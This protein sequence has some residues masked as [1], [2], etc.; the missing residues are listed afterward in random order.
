MQ[1][2]GLEVSVAKFTEDGLTSIISACEDLTKIGSSMKIKIDQTHVMI[3]A[4]NQVKN[5]V[6]AMKTVEWPITYM[7]ES[8]DLPVA[9]MDFVVSVPKSFAKAIKQM[10]GNPEVAFK[11]RTGDKNAREMVASDGILRVRFIGGM[12]SDITDVSRADVHKKLDA[13]NSLFTFD[14]SEEDFGKAKSLAATSTAESVTIKIKAGK[15]EISAEDRYYLTVGH[16]SWQ[17]TK[18]MCFD[19]KYLRSIASKGGI[20]IHVFEHFMLIVEG[21]TH[22]MIG[23]EI[24]EL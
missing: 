22:F 21:N 19:K 17:G 24:D 10:S 18:T 5:Y 2:K 3:Y 8:H 1:Q 4:T 20:K 7:F 16:I 23:L 15:V 14:I 6:M 13:A 9:G 12:P 11:Y